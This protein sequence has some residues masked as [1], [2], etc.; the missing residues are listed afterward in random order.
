MPNPRPDRGLRAGRLYARAAALSLAVA[1]TAACQS[2]SVPGLN[3]RARPSTASPIIGSIAEAG[4]PVGVA[5]SVRGAPVRG[6]TVW[7]RIT[8][9]RRG[10]VTSYY[11]RTTE[12]AP[13]VRPC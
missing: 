5:C 3:I 7:Y 8:T 6:N 12:K 4:A 11:I 13:A 2:T 1:V 10:Y 9:P